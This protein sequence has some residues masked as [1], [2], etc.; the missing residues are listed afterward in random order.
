M[1]IVPLDAALEPLFWE[2]VNQDILHYFFFVLDWT[3]DRDQTTIL[4]ALEE[5]QIEG[6]MIIYMKYIVQL[7]GSPK[8]AKALLKNLNLKTVELQA[9]ELHKPYILELF[10]PIISSE[11]TLLTLKKDQEKLQINHPVID[12]TA[13]DAVQIASLIKDA[14]PD[15]WGTITSEEITKGMNQEIW[16]GIKVKGHLV[17][18]GRAY[19]TKWAGVIAVIATRKSHQNKGYATSI[20]SELVKHLFEKQSV[21]LLHVAHDE[22]SPPALRIYTKVGFTPYRDYFF[23]RG[24]RIR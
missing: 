22:F 18:I 11:M 23:M 19:I 13:S 14:D 21:V 9:Q 10:T 20:V 16:L 6:M 7:R 17:S 3:Q 2:Y 8:A 15:F 12:L 5:N 24:D 4:L 1:E